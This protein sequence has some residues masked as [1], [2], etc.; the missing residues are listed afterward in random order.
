[1]LNCSQVSKC[2]VK[3]ESCFTF[4]S[5]DS[6][7]VGFITLA[8]GGKIYIFMFGSYCF[9]VCFVCFFGVMIFQ[10]IIYYCR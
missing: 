9:L 1:M 2:S 5:S 8:E 7:I 4:F 3:L 6:L 10:S